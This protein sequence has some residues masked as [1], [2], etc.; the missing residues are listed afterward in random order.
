M[1][2]QTYQS[3]SIQLIICFLKPTVVLYPRGTAHPPR[4]SL[5][6]RALQVPL[7][8]LPH[9]IGYKIDF[10]KYI[11][12][13]N[14][15]FIHKVPILAQV[16]IISHQVTASV[17]SLVPL[18]PYSFPC[19]LPCHPNYFF[20]MRVWFCPTLGRIFQFSLPLSRRKSKALA[21]HT[22]L[23]LIGTLLTSS[24]SSPDS[25]S[26]LPRILSQPWTHH[27][28]PISVGTESCYCSPGLEVLHSF[29]HLE[30]KF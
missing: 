17:I 10:P 8:H 28:F 21:G 13:L 26:Q 2:Q 24:A 18:V 14:L 9:L 3:Q 11:F 27:A 29:L 22:G 23:F 12:N 20:Q 1:P 5:P 7:I 4:H 16:L 25:S 19:L 15:L 6:V 30:L